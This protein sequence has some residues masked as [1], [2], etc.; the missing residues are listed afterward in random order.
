MGYPLGR[1][2]N[3]TD[4]KWVSLTAAVVMQIFT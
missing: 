4:D 3:E 2:Y 1:Q